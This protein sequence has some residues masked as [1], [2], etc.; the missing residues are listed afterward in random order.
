MSFFEALSIQL[1]DAKNVKELLEQSQQNAACY[2]SLILTTHNAIS[3]LGVANAMWRSKLHDAFNEAIE[4]GCKDCIK[5]LKAYPE[6]M[7]LTS[8]IH[9]ELATIATMLIEV[10][11]KFPPMLDDESFEEKMSEFM[12]EVKKGHIKRSF[13]QSSDGDHNDD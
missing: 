3:A 10:G 4:C 5:Q 13:D 2:H 1:D 12:G 11:R 7:A 8:A 6:G 9:T